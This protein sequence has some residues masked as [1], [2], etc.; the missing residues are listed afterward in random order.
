M[1]FLLLVFVVGLYQW[2]LIPLTKRKIG[3]LRDHT[4]KIFYDYKTK[5]QLPFEL[6]VIAVIVLLIITLTP[7][8]HFGTVFLV[9]VGMIAILVMRG[10]LEK[11]YMADF[12]HHVISFLHAFSL[13]FAF[14][15]VLIYAIINS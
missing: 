4:N 10:I 1:E 8:L 3:Y 15:C 13:F 5:W 9:P 11:K 7:F 12:R 14:G 2:I 6:A